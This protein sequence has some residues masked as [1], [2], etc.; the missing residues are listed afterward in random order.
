MVSL[1]ATVAGQNVTVDQTGIVSGDSIRYS[2]PHFPI[3]VLV[4][5]SFLGA[6]GMSDPAA[7][8]GAYQL[9]VESGSGLY[10]HSASPMAGSLQVQFSGPVGLRFSLVR[11]NTTLFGPVTVPANFRFAR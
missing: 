10:F 11:N 2:T 1:R 9:Q 4:S 7:H 6:D 5:A 3:D 8:S